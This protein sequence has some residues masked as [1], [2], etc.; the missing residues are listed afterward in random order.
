MSAP[1]V[2]ASLALATFTLWTTPALALGV[3]VTNEGPSVVG[4]AHTFTATVVDAMGDVAFTWNFG[5][6]GDLEPGTAEMTHT[7]TAPGHYTVTVE[8]MDA[9]GDAASWSF[10]HMVHHP[11]TPERPTS[12]TSIIYDSA[13]NR[14]FS[15]NQDNDT[16]TSI[17]PE[18]LVKVAE[19]PVYKRPESLALTP[20]GK[21]WVVHQDDYAVA[22]VDPD[23]FEIERGFRLPYASQPVGI[24]VS[25]TGDAAYVSLLAVGKLL[26][27]DP[28]TGETLG[29]CDVGPRPRGVAVS[30]DGNAVYV[31]RFI[32]SDEG[33]EVVQVDART[34][35]VSTRILLAL[36]AETAD[37]P[38]A[39][40][41]VPN[42]LFSVAL[43]PDGRQ[44]WVPGK[45]DNILRG[46]LRD[47]ERLTHDTTVRPLV[48]VIDAAMS[49]EIGA[50]RIDLDDRSLPVHVEFTPFGNLAIVTLGG[51]NR[52]ELRDV[53]RP[54][55]VFSAIGSVGAFPRASVLGP[56]K[57]L[58]VQGSLSRDV[59]VYNLSAALDYFDKG[60]PSE[61]AVIPAVESEKLS[62][63]ILV[64]KKLFHD[65]EDMRMANEGY[66]SCAVCHFDGKDDGRVY[67]F[68]DR[69]EG[70]RNTM[71]LLGRKGTAHGNLNWSGNFDEVQDSEHLIREL[72]LGRGFMSDEDFA[73]GTRSEPLG[74]AK[75]GVSADLDALAT[76]V[77]SLDHVNPSPYRNSNG[78]L[79]PQ[80]VAG[81][82]VFE[83]LGCDFCHGGSDF[84]DS[85]RGTLHDVG[86]L[87]EASGTRAGEPLFGIDTPTLLG[88]WETAPYLH[89]GSAP[90]LRDVLT[91]KNPDD[92]HGY[93]SALSPEE[94]D[95]LVAYV[96]QIDNELPVRRLPFDPP[97]PDGGEGSGGSAGAMGGSAG[98]MGGGAGSGAVTGGSGG[99]GGTNGG[100]HPT[101][102][103]NR[104][105]RSSG[106]QCESAMGSTRRE[107]TGAIS[108]LA[109][110]VFFGIG[111]MRRR[112][113]TRAAV[114][115]AL[116]VPLGGCGSD[117]PPANRPPAPQ[118]GTGGTA[119]SGGTGGSDWSTLPAVT[120]PDRELSK[121]ASRQ[122]AYERVCGRARGDAFARVLCGADG[123]PEI[124]GMTD[125]L[126]LA[127]LGEERAFALTGN[128]TSLVA[129]S[130]SAINPRILVF[131]RVDSEL[132][133][134]ETMTALGFVRGEQF[135][136][137]VSRDDTSDD[138]NFYLIAFEQACSYEAA[139]CDLKS[140]LTDEIEHDWTAYSVYDHDDLEGTSFDCKS[141]HEPGG[142]GSKR[143]LRMQ[144]LASPWMHWFPQ[145]FVQRTESDRILL[146]E[147]SAAHDVDRE[148]G[149]IPISVITNA[150]DEGSSAQLEALVRAEG[151]GEQPNEFDAQ[152]AAE[153]KSGSSPTWQ[154]RFDVHLRGEAIAV[155]YLGIDVTDEAKR[156][157]AVQ[158]YRDVA[159][160]AAPR[161]SL[162]DIRQVFTDDATEKLSFVPQPGADGRTVLLQMCA[163]CHDGRGNPALTKNRFDALR[164]DEMS[165]EV[166][167]LAISRITATDDLRM[168]P[169]RS[170]SLTP[171]AIQAATA[172]LSQ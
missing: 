110:L 147:F 160:G 156:A 47:G 157:A 16:I 159:S 139:G 48:A 20:E 148:Y 82:A 70:L 61:I 164:L 141:C 21:L 14:I 143:I 171:E 39:A 67:D 31:T 72:F 3:D 24:A 23:R 144:E 130:V 51:S 74:D 60:T 126:E 79:T 165:R 101:S 15:V 136:E 7:F 140:L 78:S 119:G 155:P 102:S 25:P 145:R 18:E 57:R 86:T 29:E 97:E 58:F 135:V 114:L 2:A 75:A 113:R 112:V 118:G 32:A 5:E 83:R 69:G 125:L 10:Q 33:G 109:L 154:A 117:D 100:T 142:P 9:A 90:T 54:T 99:V 115:T 163:R 49:E 1:R 36:D 107:R 149:G 93:V 106:C 68:G 167:D 77:A 46:M 132:E 95:E 4:E 40:R 11:L 105:S 85:M 172:E 63:E 52:V 76:Y 133:R 50:N 6:T 19:L 84:T 104:S 153:M 166:R 38:Q 34:M 27:L 45:K 120:H 88:V 116:A 138:L 56:N 73:V 66:M 162:L 13:R 122:A 81:K 121:L 134:P 44:A 169:W 98:A 151:F 71:A 28:S 161:E 146:A 41:G 168:P 158:S 137:I 22:V 129:M 64:G 124:R 123:R 131:P 108:A 127:G 96:E 59:R 37:G 43:T 150:L 17:D 92:L 8:V 65:S 111:A 53:N 103:D 89:D 128:S 152:I 55:Q 94:L 12:S 42:Y 80:G 35:Q 87:T 91:S 30:H 170:G 62:P 26:K